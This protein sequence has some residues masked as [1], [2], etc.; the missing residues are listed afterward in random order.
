[1]DN[2]KVEDSYFS[3]KNTLRIANKLF[4]L[5]IPQVMGIVN[6]TPDSFYAASRNENTSELMERVA[7]HIQGGA[8]IL[9]IGGY[10]TRPGCVDI[11]VEEEIARV[12]PAIEAIRAKYP[13]VVLS[14]DTFRGPVAEAAILAGAGIINDISGG[15][16]DPSIWSVA[17]KY[18]VPYILMHMR[19]TPQNMQDFCHYDN[20][21]KEVCQYFS[22]KVERLRLLGVEDI[23]L[24]PGFGFSKSVEQN[25]ALFSSLPEMRFLGLPILVGISRKSMIYKKL[26]ITAEE[27]LNGT[28]A[29]N[30]KAILSGAKILRVHDVKEAKQ[31]IDLL[32][33]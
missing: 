1:M 31:V 26:G 12:V 23:I 27:S 25:Y 4:D 15:E 10:S 11:S 21:F 30:A 3:S 24:D 18:K 33:F 16:I 22:E 19:G 17:A 14:V 32:Q 5:Q 9:D 20:I 29:L 13:D 28:T 2:S 6:V 7:T 8:S